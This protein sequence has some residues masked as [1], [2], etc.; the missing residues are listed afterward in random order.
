[1]A[2]K[3]AMGRPRGVESRSLPR[4][5]FDSNVLVY[6]DDSKDIAKQKKAV[7]LIFEHGSQRAAVLSFQILGEYFSVATRRLH[8]DPALARIQVEFYSKFPLFEI[9]LADVFAAIDIHRLHG[10]PYWDALIIRSAERSGCSVL[11]SE[12]MQHG[13]TIDGVRIVNPFL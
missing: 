7:D 2:A 12:D 1:M 5:F 8:L 3:V 10:I 13:R 6:A 4:A 9:S 11:L